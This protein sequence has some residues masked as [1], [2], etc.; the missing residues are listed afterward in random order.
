MKLNFTDHSFTYLSINSYI[1][2]QK[3][4]RMQ[5]KMHVVLCRANVDYY[6]LLSRQ[7]ILAFLHNMQM[8]KR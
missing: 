3:P 5:Q 2:F 7:K 6:L 4:Q 8:T 1:Y